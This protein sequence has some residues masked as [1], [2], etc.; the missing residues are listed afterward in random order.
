MRVAAS[1]TVETLANTVLCVTVILLPYHIVGGTCPPRLS[2]PLTTLDAAVGQ[3]AAR[4][5]VMKLDVEVRLLDVFCHHD[6]LSY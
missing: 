1:L 2:A 4:I 3:D 5:L 6:K